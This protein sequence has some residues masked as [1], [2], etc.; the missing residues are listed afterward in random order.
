MPDKAMMDVEK[1]TNINSIVRAIMKIANMML[2]TRHHAPLTN[3]PLRLSAVVAEFSSTKTVSG[4][5]QRGI[6]RTM[7]SGR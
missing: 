3:S 6:L 5:I 2:N 1:I 4:K 7:H